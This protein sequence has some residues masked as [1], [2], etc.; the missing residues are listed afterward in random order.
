MN[1]ALLLA[2]CAL[3][4]APLF[5]SPPQQPAFRAGVDMVAV[6]VHAVDDKGRP[7]AGRVVLIVVD[8]ENIGGGRQDRTH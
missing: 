6:D 5:G 7:V 3:L 2:P 8:Q 1:R 4:F